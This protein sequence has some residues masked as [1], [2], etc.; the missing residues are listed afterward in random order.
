[1]KIVVVNN[2]KENEKTQQ[3]LRNLA[4]CTGH[5]LEMLDYRIPDLLHTVE[6][7]DPDMVILTGSNYMLS[8]LDTQLVFQHEM[9][10][11]RKSDT[12]F[13]GIC[14]GHQLIGAAYGSEVADLGNTVRQFKEV[15]LLKRDLLFDGLPDSIR[16][17]ESHRQAL[18]N[19]PDGFRH[20]AESA[21]SRVEAIGHETRPVY[22]VQ[23]HPERS[24]REHP[25]GRMIIQNFLRIAKS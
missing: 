3:A 15:K 25:H 17:S 5:H 14:F 2:Y 7:M 11:V 9:D 24:D 10:L 22:G 23:F 16:V 8:K 18:S 12:P 4:G 1:L 21:T 6:R 20:L 13:L 19:V